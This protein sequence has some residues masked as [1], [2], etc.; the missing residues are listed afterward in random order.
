VSVVAS[1]QNV[2]LKEEIQTM[3]NLV[4]QTWEEEVLEQ[5]IK[6]GEER[7]E[8]RGSRKSLRLLLEERFGT[9]PEVWAKRIEAASD[10]PRLEAALRQAVKVNSLDELK[11]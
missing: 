6:V 5:G 9:L 10:V 7:G 3:G 8:L 11:L 1:E 2:L 4:E